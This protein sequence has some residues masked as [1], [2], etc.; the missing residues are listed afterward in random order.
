MVRVR[1][2]GEGKGE[3]REREGGGNL[4]SE[5]VS[6]LEGTTHHHLHVISPGSEYTPVSGLCFVMVS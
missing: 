5:E 4:T 1:G 3:G 6:L 2:K